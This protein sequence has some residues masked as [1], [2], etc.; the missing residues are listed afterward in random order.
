MNALKY[1]LID[2]TADVGI[3][4]FGATLPELFSNAAFAMFDIMADLERV[5]N[6]VEC[7]LEITGIDRE[8]LLVNW[9][10]ELLYLHDVKNYLFKN[11]LIANVTDTRLS[12][13]VHGEAFVEN[14]HIIKTEIKAVTYHGLSIVQEG[15]QWKARVIFDL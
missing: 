7:S 10:G 15:Q 11:F 12:A 2:H 9:L 5:E 1:I 6:K 3:E 13:I 14:K 8:Q 4:A